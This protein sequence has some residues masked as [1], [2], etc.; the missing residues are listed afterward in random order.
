M[1]TITTP[2]LSRAVTRS[3]EAGCSATCTHC[4]EPVKFRAKLKL[5]QVICNVYCDG[6]WN[7]VEHFHEECYRSAGAPYGVAV[8]GGRPTRASAVTSSAA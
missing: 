8:D 1:A 4:D 3:I 5:H 6:A 2:R 7:R